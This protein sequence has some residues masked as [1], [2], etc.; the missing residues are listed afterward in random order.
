[1]TVY[2]RE[3]C[4]PMKVLQVGIWKDHILGGCRIF[5]KGLQLNGCEVSRFDY[6]GTAQLKGIELMN[7]LMIEKAQNV[8]LVFIGKG[9]LIAP[10]TLERIRANGTRI[11]LWYGDIRLEPEPWLTSIGNYLDC[12]FLSSSGDA[13]RRYHNRL[14]P[15]RSA[16]FF[17]PS[18]PELVKMYGER[19]QKR[20]NV[21][22]TG[23]PYVGGD[24]G[25]EQVVRYLYSRRDTVFYGGIET[26]C[27]K[28]PASQRVRG[29]SY[30][31]VIKQA[32][33]G[34]GINAYNHIP[35][36]SSD[37]LT[38]YLTFGTFFLSSSFPR[39]EQ[40]F[41]VGEEIVTFRDIDELD[42]LISFYLEHEGEREALAMNGQRAILKRFHCQRMVQMMLEVLNRG[43]SD[44][45]DWVEV[46]ND[47]SW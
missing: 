15:K 24:G 3:V 12:F 9:E 18:D 37:R 10:K 7:S 40:L 47:Q 44:M 43:R 30:I 4:C 23:T 46:I 26:L 17:N 13:L 1:M 29:R 28:Q 35:G 33:I 2:G 21:L 8:D 32:R 31:S 19:T 22:L 14:R 5:E 16:Y 42:Q 38:H 34:I 20:F 36:Y 27:S 39:V 45:Y 25:R 11:V 6:R 41:H